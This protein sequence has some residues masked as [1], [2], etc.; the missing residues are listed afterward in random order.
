MDFCTGG[1]IQN[2]GETAAQAFARV[3][4]TDEK[5]IA[6]FRAS[7]VA[8]G[9]DVR[10]TPMPVLKAI[11]PTGAAYRAIKKLADDYRDGLIAVGKRI[12][13][14]QAFTKIFTDP[15]N[16]ALRA[17]IRNEHIV[18]AMRRAGHVA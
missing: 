14:E 3:V 16:A 13:A 18:A 6:L 12:S 7:K 8:P 11:E 1:L 4:T 5:A 10:P 17:E 9:P 15:A 2:D